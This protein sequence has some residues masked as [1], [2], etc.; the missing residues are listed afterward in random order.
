MSLQR[1]IGSIFSMWNEFLN[2]HATSLEIESNLCEIYRWAHSNALPTNVPH[3]HTFFEACLVGA[4]GEGIFRNEGENYPLC[5]HT[6]FL[7][8]PG[9]LHQIINTGPHDMELYWVSFAL[10]RLGQNRV[11]ALLKAFESSPLV[12][13]NAQE[14]LGAIWHALRVVAGS[15]SSS[16]NEGAALQ[17]L[18]QA[19]LLE[20]AS[21]GSDTVAPVTKGENS[22]VRA[23]LTRLGAQYVHDNLDR[24]L[25]PEEVARHMGVS[26]RHLTR[27]FSAHTGLPPMLY[28]ERARLDRARGLLRAGQKSV[29]EVAAL[30]GYHDVHHFTRSFTRVVGISPAQYRA[31]GS[32]Y[33]ARNSGPHIQNPGSLV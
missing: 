30:V 33:E 32:L 10:P 17:H 1:R 12:M 19:L 27:L 20:I 29:K 6:F 8:R 9:A 4:H 13:A 28:I 25:T 11:S 14:S 24:P 31:E 2:Q 7:A 21:L 22:S 26:R 3:R 16:V 15:P 23:R 5:P 18:A